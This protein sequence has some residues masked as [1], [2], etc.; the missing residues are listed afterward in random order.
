[1]Y[2]EEH[3]CEAPRSVCPRARARGSRA[4]DSGRSNYSLQSPAMCSVRESAHLKDNNI[5]HAKRTWPSLPIINSYTRSDGLD[6]SQCEP[7]GNIGG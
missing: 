5:A 7:N 6:V 1:M 4:E 3:S 2:C